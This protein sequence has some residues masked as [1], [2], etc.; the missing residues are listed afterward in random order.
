[1]FYIGSTFGF[2]CQGNPQLTKKDKKAEQSTNIKSIEITIA[3][4]NR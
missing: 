3:S 4:N 1:M 2:E